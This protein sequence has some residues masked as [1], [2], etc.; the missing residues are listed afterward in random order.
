M[1]ESRVLN[2]INK[3]HM[4]L[5]QDICLVGLS[6][7][8]DSVCL[9]SLL[10][11][12][13]TK[14]GYKL[15]AIHVNHNLRGEEAK[16][17]A[18]YARELCASRDIPYYEYSYEVKELSE[19]YHM[20]TE[21]MGRKVRQEA[22]ADC[23][24]KYG[25]TKLA[26]A[27]HQNDLAETFLFHLA[28]GTSL[29]GLAA[30]RAVR[31]D[32]IRPLLCMNRKEIEQYLKESKIPYCE[33]STN[34]EDAYTR[35]QIRHHV[36][37]YLTEEVNKDTVSHISEVSEDILEVHNYME[38]QAKRVEDTETVT[39]RK[40]DACGLSGEPQRIL[41][42]MGFFQEPHILQG[43]VLISAIE[44]LCGKRKNITREHVE[45]VLRLKDASVG[46][47]VSLPHGVI[48]VRN[49]EN[50]ELSIQTGKK[51]ISLSEIIEIPVNDSIQWGDFTIETKTST[52]KGE[53]IPE[54]TYTK[55]FDYDRIKQNAVFRTRRSGDYLIINASGGHK[56]LKDY[57]I[58]CKVPRNERD[59]LLLLTSQDEVLWVVGYRIGESAKVSENTK[60]MIEIHVTGGNTNE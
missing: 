43:M 5:P 13:Q 48:A 22:Y 27:H 23:M 9:L 54:K 41:L 34:A 56:K 8:A 7:G 32:V 60:Q 21:E 35:N 57:L 49:Y 24:K 19:E 50:V 29:G 26:L 45:L 30:I 12:L 46:K 1:I 53:R 38:A 39:C 25:A 16:R 47:Q 17:D 3:Y 40:K 20:G 52:Y 58:D 42:N 28:R 37:S 15:Q 11:N 36:V 59:R 4:L 18:S 6:G 10:Y 33:D 31:G 2:Y 55:W 44:R 14:I 51:D